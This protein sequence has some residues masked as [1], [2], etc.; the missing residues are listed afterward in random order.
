MLRLALEE[1]VDRSTVDPRTLGRVQRTVEAALPRTRADAEG[2][3]ARPSDPVEAFAFVGTRYAPRTTPAM[4][5]ALRR[6]G[7]DDL[8]IL[9]LAIAVADANQWARQHRLLGLP[10]W[11]LYV[12]DVAPVSAGVRDAAPREPAEGK[13]LPIH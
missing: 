11:L 3:H 13:A 8:G 12:D 7:W 4:I 9:D 6:A 5:D 1:Q 10:A 2:F